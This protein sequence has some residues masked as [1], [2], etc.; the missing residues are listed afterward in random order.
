MYGCRQGLLMGQGPL[1]AW[2]PLMGR[3]PL[4]GQGLAIG[5]G[6]FL[7]RVPSHR[8]LAGPSQDWSGGGSMAEVQKVQVKRTLA[9]LEPAKTRGPSHA[10]GCCPGSV[11]MAPHGAESQCPL[12]MRWA[13]PAQPV[14]SCPVATRKQED[15]RTLVMPL[16]LTHP[17]HCHLLW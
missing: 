13:C 10:I 15:G 16:P 2:G 6:P 4:T 9:G 11:P 1:T 7:G 8:R 14:C 17:C 5:Q 3:G 12:S